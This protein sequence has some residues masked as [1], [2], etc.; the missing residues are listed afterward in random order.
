MCNIRIHLVTADVP[1][2]EPYCNPLRRASCRASLQSTPDVPAAEPHCNPLRRASGRVMCVYEWFTRF[3]EGVSDNPVAE[4]WQSP[5]SDENI[6]E[7][8]RL[9]T[10]DRQLTVCMTAPEL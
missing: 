4:D 1:A 6:E 7:E 2:A 8:K 5:D 9:I 10:K 3:G